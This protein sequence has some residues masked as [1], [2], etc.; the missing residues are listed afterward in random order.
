MK[1]EYKEFDF[2][3]NAPY[4]TVMGNFL[5]KHG[6]YYADPDAFNIDPFRIFGN[7]YYVGDKKVCMHLVDTGD[8]LILF[9]SGYSNHYDALIHSIESLGF[10]PKDIKFVI[11]S[12]GHFD[13]FGG[14]NRLRDRYGAKILMSRVDTDLIREEPRRALMHL[15]PE[16][17]DGICWPD[18][19]LE[20]GEVI[21]L[22]NTKIHC[23]L[24]P[25]H[26]FG[27]M[28]F[29]FD[30]SDGD[31]T[32][33]AGYFGGVGFLTVYKEY[34]REYGLPE[35]KS[36]KMGETIKK[37]KKEK[38][39][40]VLGNHPNQNCTISKREYMIENPNKNPF[41]NP[42]AWNEFLTALEESRQ[43]FIQRGY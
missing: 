29:F 15:A 16:G 22:G 31:K 26:T 20:D 18:K 42:N 9:D 41:I 28:A 14:G 11:H 36:E 7:L 25:G 39:D 32:L 21:A 12:H 17:H 34:C 2:A 5:P 30:V 40:I 33:R 35:N 3:P 19:T 10:S 23:V 4:E 24:A 6:P 1:A 37:L 8:G 38:V 43:D 27:T 13:H